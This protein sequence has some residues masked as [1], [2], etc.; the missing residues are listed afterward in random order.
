[1]TV[2]SMLHAVLWRSLM[3]LLHEVTHDRYASLST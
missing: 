3:M 1:M 2:Y